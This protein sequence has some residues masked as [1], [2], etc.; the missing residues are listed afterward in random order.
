MFGANN[1]NFKYVSLA[2]SQS[3]SAESAVWDHLDKEAGRQKAGN[4][5]ASC[6]GCG[7]VYTQ[8]PGM[9]WSHL[10]DCKGTNDE[11]QAALARSAAVKF[12]LE[13]AEKQARSEVP[14]RESRET[15]SQQ[16]PPWPFASSKHL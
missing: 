6:K 15:G 10:L 5:R 8:S 11:E 12:Q 16:L 4:Q 9:W 7:V 3:S 13:K 2:P 1:Q 14:A